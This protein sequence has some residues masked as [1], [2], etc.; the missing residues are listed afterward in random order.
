MFD[1][2]LNDKHDLLVIPQGAPLPVTD[3]LAKWR[4]KKTRVIGVSH[5]IRLAV[6]KQ[7]YYMRKARDFGKH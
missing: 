1:V 4:K 7:G 2:Y 3:A 6:Q 5:E